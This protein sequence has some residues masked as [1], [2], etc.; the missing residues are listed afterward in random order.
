MHHRHPQTRYS[1]S[2]PNFSAM[3]WATLSIIVR[4]SKMFNV[5]QFENVYGFYA[6]VNLGSYAPEDSGRER[7]SARQKK[8]KPVTHTGAFKPLC[9]YR[10]GMGGS[11]R[12]VVQSCEM[13]ISAGFRTSCASCAKNTIMTVFRA[14]QG[15]VVRS[16]A[17]WD[18]IYITQESAL[19]ERLLG[20]STRSTFM[21]PEAKRRSIDLVSI[22][23]E[24]PL[25]DGIWQNTLGA[26]FMLVR[27][28]A[29]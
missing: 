21:A 11:V 28:S 23:T 7:L 14:F 4:A 9:V 13:R 16:C 26:K 10:G 15:V 19:T 22:L 8:L 29:T 20:P 3:A 17:N 18:G 6:G 25:P 12:A 27:P 2:S 5:E 24:A 1:D